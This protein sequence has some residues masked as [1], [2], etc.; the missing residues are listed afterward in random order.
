MYVV[1]RV[2][3][4]VATLIVAAAPV[5]VAAPAGAAAPAT[6][7]LAYQVLP[8]GK[9]VVMR[10]NPCRGHTYKVN[11]ASVPSASRK[12][13]LAETHAAV[14]LL[15]SRSGLRFTYKGAT[16]EVPRVGSYAK[17]SADIIIA[18]T[19]PSK[20]NY[21]LSGSTAGVGGYSDRS[22]S[23]TV[24][25]T[26]TYTLA[27]TKGFLVIDTPDALRYFKAGFGTGVRRGN[28]LLH[29]L[30][31]VV[32]LGHMNNRAVLMNPTVTSRTPN[33]YATGDRAGLAKVG[34]PA[35]CISGF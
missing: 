23:S 29:E 25:G 8:N 7:K 27:I 5:M 32:G 12:V 33:G 19:T 1:T 28:L 11:L 2:I 30:G 35:G 10:W 20:T 6:Y 15:A 3:A 26:T 18:Y 16:R 24:G 34:R 31:H 22:Q 13:I 4:V 21:R 14:R 17:Q 9:K